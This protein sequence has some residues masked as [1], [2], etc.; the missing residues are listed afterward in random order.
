MGVDPT[1]LYQWK[2][3]KQE[4]GLGILLEIENEGAESRAEHAHVSNFDQRQIR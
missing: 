4:E 3:W 1:S 2:A